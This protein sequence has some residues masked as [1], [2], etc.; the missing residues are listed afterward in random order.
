VKMTRYSSTLSFEGKTVFFLILRFHRSHR[1]SKIEGNIN[2]L[3]VQFN[4]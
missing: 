1:Y 2:F 4:K 3:N